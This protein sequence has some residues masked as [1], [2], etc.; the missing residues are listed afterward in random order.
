MEIGTYSFGIG[1]RFAM[2]GLYQLRA[3][4]EAARQGIQLSPVWN[5]SN[6][7]HG[8]VHSDPDETRIAAE[9]AVRS[10]N[11]E[12]G[13]FLDADHIN[14]SNVDKFIP[15][16]NFF[17]LDVA[18]FIG[19]KPALQ[20]IEE[21][22]ASQEKH[23]GSFEIP[24]INKRFLVTREF[25]EQFALN[26]LTAIEGAGVLY[27]YIEAQKGKGNFITEVSMDEVENPQSPLELFFI[28]H[29]LA[30]EGV[31]VQTI[32][33][34]FTGRFNK[35]VDY[36][37]NLEQ[38]AL[39]FEED[40]FVI[41][42]VIADTGLPVD[43]KLSIHSGSDKFS[44]YPIIGELIRKHKVGIHIKTAGTTWL[45]EVIGLA[46]GGGDALELAKKIYYKAVD[47]YDELTAPYASV[48]AIEQSALP[49]KEAVSKWTSREFADCLR[50]DQTNKDYNP[51]FRQLIHVAYKI[52]A[53]YQN[54][55]VQMIKAN[56][57][58]VG[59]QVYENL[60]ERHICRIFNE[61]DSGSLA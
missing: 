56:E 3:F 6:R 14:L 12:G 55:Y 57:E 34:K 58:I 2:Q 8:I 25:L 32:A 23:I 45:E 46:L 54:I 39:E 22:I 50:H 41:K 9:I 47:R 59:K 7:E 11:W 17:T 10:A 53:E 30:R 24:G 49:T 33:P 31:P 4:Q 26:Y 16:C 20:N 27:R 15:C 38:F 35:G 44:L 60:W 42:Q 43:L 19:Q 28:L 29:G 37:G 48:I 51:N 5:K 36:A 61:E 13:Y 21:F 18:E 52:A 40:L 1:D